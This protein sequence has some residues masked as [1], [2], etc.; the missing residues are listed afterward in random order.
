MHDSRR[1]LFHYRNKIAKAI[2]VENI[3][4]LTLSLG[5]SRDGAVT[6][7]ALIEASWLSH[8]QEHLWE[9]VMTNQKDCVGPGSTF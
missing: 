9:Q 5:G 2:H 1:S 7:S 6:G 4:Y 8:G 3:V